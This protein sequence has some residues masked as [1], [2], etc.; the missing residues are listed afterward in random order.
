MPFT[1]EQ[2]DRLDDDPML[3]RCYFWQ[4]GHKALL[5][6]VTARKDG[7]LSDAQ[8]EARFGRAILDNIDKLIVTPAL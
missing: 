7:R 4:V 5:R 1:E 3:Q 2:M 8:F 6:S